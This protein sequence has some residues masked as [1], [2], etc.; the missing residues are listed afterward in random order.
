M[1][2]HGNMA[3]LTNGPTHTNH[4]VSKELSLWR[5]GSSGAPFRLNWFIRWIVPGSLHGASMPT[6]ILWSYCFNVEMHGI[7]V[8]SGACSDGRNQLAVSRRDEVSSISGHS[9][10]SNK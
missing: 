3:K 2:A 5:N 9:V 6:F 1:C 8:F 10:D 4:W 7:K